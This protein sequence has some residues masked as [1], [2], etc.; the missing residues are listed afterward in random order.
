MGSNVDSF[1]SREIYL[2]CTCARLPKTSCNYA[3]D[4]FWQDLLYKLVPTDAFL[5]CLPPIVS[6][7]TLSPLFH[8]PIYQPVPLHLLTRCQTSSCSPFN[9]SSSSSRAKRHAARYLQQ[10]FPVLN[11]SHFR[12]L[13]LGLYSVSDSYIQI[14]QTC[15]LSALVRHWNT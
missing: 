10:C 6:L 5:L 2:S 14:L 13:H 9:N 7:K 15:T 8:L 3:V 12:C 11:L 1:K 4:C